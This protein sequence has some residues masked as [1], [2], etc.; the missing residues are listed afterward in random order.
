M[1]LYTLDDQFR[2]NEIVENHISMIWTERFRTE[3][4]FELVVPATP[5]AKTMLKEGTWLSMSESYRVMQ[6]KDVNDKLEDGERTLKVTGTSLEGILRD[7]VAAKAIYGKPA[8][9]ESWIFEKT[10]VEIIRQLFHDIC[11]L[12]KLN[13]LDVIPNV[14][15]GVA[16]FPS[17]IEY[18]SVPIKVSL[19]ISTL[20]DAI[21]EMCDNWDLGFRL[22]RLADDKKLSWDVYSG[23]DR[24]SGQTKLNPVIF[25]PQLGNLTSTTEYSSIFE[26][27]NVAYV[28]CD[29]KA[30]E[31][32]P[33]ISEQS[34]RGLSRKVL[35]VNASDINSTDFPDLDTALTQRGRDELAK[36]KAYKG[37]DGEIQEHSDYIYQRD[38]YLG[39]L[40][41]IVNDNGTKN[42]MRVTEH[43]FVSDAEGNR[44]YPTLEKYNYIE[45]GSW[46]SWEYNIFWKSLESDPT[47][48]SQQE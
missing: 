22:L 47:T 4:D 31:V 32:Y 43:I 34:I 11:V 8:E 1:L 33:L 15:E 25:S 9:V 28:F 40:V 42:I 35:F 46:D 44:A 14:T 19:T 7:R 21:A 6:I 39:D 12:G 18:P 16:P 13:P 37:F 45:V 10:P 26:A 17:N 2:R 24:T 27:K 5:S 20:Y 30:L 36:H 29:E 3:G 41:D 48:W 23:S 38:Y